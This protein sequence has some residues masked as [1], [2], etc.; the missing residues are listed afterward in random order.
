MTFVKN[1]KDLRNITAENNNRIGSPLKNIEYQK[2]RMMAVI[3]RGAV[4]ACEASEGGAAM[5][6]R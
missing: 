4:V 6:F 3:A 2:F 5:P 1:Q